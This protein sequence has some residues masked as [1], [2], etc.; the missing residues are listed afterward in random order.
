M[1]ERIVP[2][3]V[4][5]SIRKLP[6]TWLPEVVSVARMVAIWVGALTLTWRPTVAVPF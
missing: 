4:T 6:V 1:T 2:P 3:S 5:C